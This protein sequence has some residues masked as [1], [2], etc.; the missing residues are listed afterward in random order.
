[1]RLI[2]NP[3]D[4]DNILMSDTMYPTNMTCRT[5]GGMYQAPLSST[6]YAICYEGDVELSQPLRLGPS[7][8]MMAG[9]V[10]SFWG[11]VDII[12]KG[13]FKLF[14]IE[15][16]GYRGLRM[17]AQCEGKGRLAYIDGCSDTTL[18]PPARYGDPALNFLHFPPEIDQTQHL[19]PD[20]RMGVV[21]GGQGVAWQADRWEKDM[22]AGAMF[23][24]DES[25]IH[26]FKTQTSSMDVIAYHPTTDTGPTDAAHAMI[27]R[28]Y[29]NHGK[30]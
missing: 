12:P 14:L 3:S 1:M 10:A 20:I 2:P 6:T 15:K 22:V 19:H 24:L 4:G 18:I 23:C 16:I 17:T 8:H 26:S 30:T 9:T 29:I 13:T 28:T 7:I 11:Q 5:V 27:S 25:E 21:L